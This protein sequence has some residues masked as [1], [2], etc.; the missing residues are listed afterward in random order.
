MSAERRPRVLV[1]EDGHE[2]ITTLRRY[3]GQAFDFARA[4]DGH[5]ALAQLAGGPWDVVF[6]DMRFDRTAPSQLLGDLAVT[7]DRFNGDTHR[8][9]RFLEEHQGTYVLAALREAG[10]GLPVVMS[11]D[12][13][14]E[15]RRWKHLEARYRPIRYLTDNADP[16]RIQQALR[17]AAATG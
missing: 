4:G 9:T 8:A 7:A 14:S 5:E 6:L 16:E 17:G 1:V 15:P 2:Y 11:Y 12:F 10:C 13:D 3:L